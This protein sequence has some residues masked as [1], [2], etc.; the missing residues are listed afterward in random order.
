MDPATLLALKR[1]QLNDER[2]NK[3]MCDSGLYEQNEDISYRSGCFVGS[4]VWTLVGLAAMWHGTK[5]DDSLN[6]V[7]GGIAVVL[8][9]FLA[10]VNYM[11]MNTNID[12][13][14]RL[15]ILGFSL[16]AKGPRVTPSVGADG[17]VTSFDYKPSRLIL[18]D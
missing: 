8:F 4:L 16:R 1:K 6:I 2:L 5:F 9:S 10:V 15:D 17:L 18:F 13:D 14:K 12:C 7:C 11:L 3:F